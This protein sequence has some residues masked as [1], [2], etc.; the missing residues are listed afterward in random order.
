MKFLYSVL[1]R[2]ISL[3]PIKHNNRYKV[4][5]FLSFSG[6]F[7]LVQRAIKRFGMENVQVLFTNEVTDLSLISRK[8]RFNNFNIIKI[9]SAIHSGKVVI[10]D[11]Y[12]PFLESVGKKKSQKFIQIWHANGAVKSFGWE[13]PNTFRRSSLDKR[14]FQRVY[15]SFDYIL[16]GSNAMASVFKNSWHIPNQKIVKIGYPRSDR[17][18]NSDWQESVIKKIQRIQPTLLEKPL[19]FYAPTYRKDLNFVL[20]TDWDSF[21]VPPDMNLAIRLH[22]HLKSMEKDIINKT[23]GT[24]NVDSRISTDEL[25]FISKV[26]ITDYSSVLFDFAINAS[27]KAA[28][29]FTYDLDSYKENVGVQSIFFNQYSNILTKKSADLAQLILKNDSTNFL[30]SVN[31]KWNTFNDG[32]ATERLLNLIDRIN[33]MS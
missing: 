28:Y 11:N 20:P 7:D 23:L 4:T 6:N 25:L 29:L 14:R 16:V 9:I 26:L 3:F 17:F 1:F 18:Y 5:F 13:D 10:F 27:N 19:I 31:D 33:T 22:P 12:F 24:I 30:K 15:D 8:E 21:V 32:H 2:I